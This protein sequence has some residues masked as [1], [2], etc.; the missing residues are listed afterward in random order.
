VTKVKKLEASSQVISAV[1]GTGYASEGHPVRSLYSFRYK[2]LNGEGLPIVVNQDGTSTSDGS[3]IHFQSSSLDNLV[4]EGPTDPTMSASLSNIFRYAGW[5]LSVFVT[6][7]FGNVIRLYPS[8]NSCYSDLTA[9]PKVF[10]NRWVLSGDEAV[11]SIPT[12]V[13]RHQYEQDKYLKSL[14]N[15]YNYST[16]RVAKG[17][18]VRMKEIALSYDFPRRLTRTLGVGGLSMKLQATNLFLFY[19]DSKLDGM[20]PEFF[21]SGGVAAPCPRQFT[22]TLRLDL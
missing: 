20:D 9:M 4:Y 2:G 3:S 15:A 6:G 14:Y 7:S 8:F 22:F 1:E 11:T 13:T 12:I 5:S 19:A 21:L 10:K 17:D 18:F 16:D